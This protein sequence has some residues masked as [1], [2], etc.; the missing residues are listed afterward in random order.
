MVDE[1]VLA[2]GGERL[3]ITHGDCLDKQLGTG[4]LKH[5]IGDVGY[6][7]IERVSNVYNRINATVGRPR[8][9]LVGWLKRRIPAVRHHVEHFEQAAA[10]LS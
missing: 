6:R 1:I 10:D 5:K 8:G 3:L 7:N 9:N 2:V 4:W